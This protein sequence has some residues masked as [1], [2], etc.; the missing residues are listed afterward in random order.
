ML[1]RA[2][3]GEIGIMARKRVKWP[4]I[5]FYSGLIFKFLFHDHVPLLPFNYMLQIQSI[6]MILVKSILVSTLIKDDVARMINTKV[7]TLGYQR[8]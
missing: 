4:R 5:S 8:H 7:T 2:M 3:H 1:D 6:K